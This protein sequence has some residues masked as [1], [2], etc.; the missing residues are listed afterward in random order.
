MG[1]RPG[2]RQLQ[3][4]LVATG[5]LVRRKR[6][7]DGSLRGPGMLASVYFFPTLAA[8]GNSPQEAVRVPQELLRLLPLD[9]DLPAVG[10]SPAILCNFAL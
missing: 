4:R 2:Y 1:K 6:Q 10:T 7:E 3:P 5:A 9:P 8:C